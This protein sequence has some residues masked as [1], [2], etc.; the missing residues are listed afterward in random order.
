[1]NDVLITSK[2]MGECFDHQECYLHA[3]SIALLPL[4][5]DCIN[6]KASASRLLLC[7]V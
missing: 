2:G 5:A 1:M 7:C 6:A 4:N 3:A